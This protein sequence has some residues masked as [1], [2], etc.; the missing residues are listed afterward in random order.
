LSAYLDSPRKKLKTN[1]VWEQNGSQMLTN[2]FISPLLIG[3]LMQ[4][5]SH[6]PIPLTT[7]YAVD[8]GKTASDRAREAKGSQFRFP[9]L[10]FGI[11]KVQ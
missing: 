4:E 11:S 6:C 1:S 3:K 10:K 9:H 5:A 7:V 2:R 8:T